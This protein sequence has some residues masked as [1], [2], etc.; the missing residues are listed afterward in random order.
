[1]EAILADV[2]VALR[3]VVRAP[4]FTL[5]A[6][7]SLAVGIGVSTA[8]YSAV[9]TL[10]WTPMG[11]RQPDR[12]AV[13]TVGGRVDGSLSWPDFVDLRSQQSTFSSVG[14][15]RPLYSAVAIGNIIETVLGESVSGDYFATLGVTAQLGRVLQPHDESSAAKVAVV[16]DAFWRTRLHADRAILGR[17]IT[18]AGEPFEVVG[19]ILGPFHGV[20]AILPGVVWIPDTAVPDRAGTGWPK[21]QLTDRALGSLLVWGRLKPGVSIAQAAAD[22]SVIAQ[23]LDATFPIKSPYD[24]AGRLHRR[25]W[26]LKDGVAANGDADRID[27]LGVAI[28]FAVAT[29]LIIACTNL[30]NLALARGTSRA[31]ETAVRAALGASRWRLIREHLIE[32]GIVTGCGGGLGLLLLWTLTRSFE[33]D[34]PVMQSLVIHFKPDVNATVL[35]VAA[36]ATTLALLV[37]GVWPALQSTRADVRGALGAGGAATPP[38]WRLHRSLVA[39][40]VAGS[41]AMVLVAGMCVKVVAAVGATDPGV[42]YRH[43][44]LAQ[45]DFD[46]NGRD[47]LR[48]RALLDTILVEARRQSRVESVSASSGLPFGVMGPPTYATRVE[49]PFTSNRDA[50]HYT[51]R[52]A[53][54]PDIFATLGMRIVRGRGFTDRDDVG[55][56]RVAILSEGIAREIFRTTD[57]VGRSISLHPWPRLINARMPQTCEVVG[58]SKETDSFML[59]RRGNPVL[60]VPLA[61]QYES[62]ITITARSADPAG[63]ASALRT[64]IRTVAPDMAT[65]ALGTGEALLMGPYF[66]LRIIAGLAAALGTIA[67]VLAMAGLHGVLSHVVARR[68]REIGIRLA[69]G[70]DRKRILSLMLR[71]GFRPVVKGLV[72]GLGAGVL[73]R[74]LLRATI[75]TAISPVD[76]TMFSLIP[77]PFLCAGL[78]ACWVPASRAS[79]V[80]PNVALRDL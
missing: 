62:R 1:M 38:R 70:A 78:A 60:F 17:S 13:W 67:L 36:G 50:G 71:D 46:I 7:V 8:V 10:F 44:A 33:T 26:L 76:V 21:R 72:I 4:G 25:A 58:V 24:L 42:D 80:D 59:G 61:Q 15:A 31:Q 20:P 34:L 18:I 28:L 19:V 57:V 37:F 73:L 55:A 54:T 65:S 6:I 23:R 48:G 52:I 66:L 68:T 53:A 29:V 74:L 3:R 56:P 77:V 47:E 22:V 75:V 41:V 43:L 2:R 32:S 5:F 49:E 16:S 45:A 12:L 35:L 11:L 14:A 69:V 79:R 40:Q 9:R 51:H 30:A 27:A 63:A 39:W 64:A